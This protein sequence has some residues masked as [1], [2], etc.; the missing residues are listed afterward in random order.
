MALHRAMLSQGV[1]S[2]LQS[3]SGSK[4]RAARRL[5]RQLW[6]LQ[7]SRVPSWRSPAKFGSLS[8]A[9]IDASD[10]DVVNLHWVTDGFLSIEQISQITKPIVWSLYDMWPFC[11]TEH[12]GVDGLQDRWRNGY[13]TGNRPPSDKGFD[14][15]R[16]TWQRKAELWSPMNVVPASWWLSDAVGSSALMRDWPR[17]RIPHVVDAEVFR[18]MPRR[19]A[20]HTLGL[21]TDVPLIVFLASA[22]VRDVR[23]GFD[24]LEQALAIIKTS[25]PE[26]G[27][28]IAGPPDPEYAASSGVELYWLGSISG[29]ERLRAVYSAA[30]VLA[31]PSREDN[32]PLTAMESQTC[33]RAVV[34][35]D[36]GGMPDIVLHQRSGYLAQA[37]DVPDLAEGLL[38]ALDDARGADIW[39]QEARSH[40]LATWSE[41][42]VVRQ[43]LD[44]YE[45]AVP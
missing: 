19:E 40:A 35:F 39:G 1:P 23:K 27:L 26:V 5:D 14:L 8:A 32:M 25:Y 12:Y 9:D 6:H 34:A 31:V 3:A 24:L 15:D 33:G 4:F 7:R 29:D 30:D 18:P 22:G 2:Q 16:W 11:G 13:T 17:T 42:V 45:S 20:R 28:A 37:E 38:Q 43:Y 36:I 44:L 10:A 21:P 41:P